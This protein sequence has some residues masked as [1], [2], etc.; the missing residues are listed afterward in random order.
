MPAPAIK[1]FYD[2]LLQQNQ[3]ETSCNLHIFGMVSKVVVYGGTGAIGPYLAKAIAQKGHDT[4]AVVRAATKQANSKK[5]N[6]LK[7]AGVKVVEGD[8]D[9]SEAELVT[10]LRNFEVVV[11]AVSSKTS[12]HLLR[13][14]SQD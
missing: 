4:T 3:P 5:I 6:A 1:R 14:G 2:E 10:F 7:A 8:L 13:S 11:S 12:P 9:V